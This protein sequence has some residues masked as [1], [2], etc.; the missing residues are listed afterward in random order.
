MP[1]REKRIAPKR[2]AISC[3]TTL[4]RNY[5]TPESSA[6]QIARGKRMVLQLE[7]VEY[8]LR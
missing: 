5:T 3:P 4:T 6:H 1:A 2:G 7:R 8:N